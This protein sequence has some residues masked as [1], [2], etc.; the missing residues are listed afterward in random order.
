[1][2]KQPHTEILW[3]VCSG[4]NHC[5]PAS[6]FKTGISGISSLWSV[7]YFLLGWQNF[8]TPVTFCNF[9]CS[10]KDP[11]WRLGSQ[12]PAITGLPAPHTCDFLLC[13]LSIDCFYYTGS[14]V[15]KNKL[16][17]EPVSFPHYWLFAYIHVF[18]DLCVDEFRVTIHCMPSFYSVIDFSL[19]TDYLYIYIPASIIWGCPSFG[20]PTAASSWH[21]DFTYVKTTD[22]FSPHAPSPSPNEPSSPWITICFAKSAG[23]SLPWLSLKATLPHTGF[24]FHCLGGLVEQPLISFGSMACTPAH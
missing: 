12:D 2:K 6:N 5:M 1:M 19:G 8:F 13:K 16:F 14:L 11:H 10:W 15:K 9:F 7:T 22:R 17:L 20:V 18:D 3:S 4:I 23:I 21:F 24:K